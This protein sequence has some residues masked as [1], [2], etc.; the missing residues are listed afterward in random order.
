MAH[1]DA[2]LQGPP[3]APERRPA[4]SRSPDQTR[5]MLTSYQDGLRQARSDLRGAHADAAGP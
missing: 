2:R 1:L 5:S 4:A 3:G